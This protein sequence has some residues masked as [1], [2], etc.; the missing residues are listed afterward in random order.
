MRLQVRVRWEY[1]NKR[2]GLPL[3]VRQEHC[4]SEDQTYPSPS[5]STLL[6]R[7]RGPLAVGQAIE[8]W[9]TPSPI[10]YEAAPRDRCTA[11]PGRPFHP[12]RKPRRS[13]AD[14]MKVSDSCVSTFN[15]FVC[16]LPDPRAA[17][18]TAC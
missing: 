12:A 13:G 16:L 8:S 7:R 15:A 17:P 9:G 2:G 11:R 14:H 5:A 1:R 6:M 10:R 3:G 4:S 18:T